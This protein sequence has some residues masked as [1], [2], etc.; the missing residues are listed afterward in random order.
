ML[1]FRI[2]ILLHVLS[3]LFLGGC[4]LSAKTNVDLLDDRFL[5]SSTSEN[6]VGVIQMDWITLQPMKT[7]DQVAMGF[8]LIGA[9]VSIAMQSSEDADNYEVETESL[10][11]YERDLRQ[12]KQ[13]LSEQSK[14]RF[15]DSDNL[16]KVD[17]VEFSRDV[18]SKRGW[19]WDEP[20]DEQIQAYFNETHHD[21]AIFVSSLGGIYE[22]DDTLFV[23]TTWGILDKAG[24]EVVSVFTRNVGGE[25]DKETIQ[26]ASLVEELSK[27][28]SKNLEEFLLVINGEMPVNSSS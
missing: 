19:G 3:L 17:P 16:E 20:S 28:F 14:Y 5:K 11:L 8:G 27:L 22:N 26:S 6:T 13:R 7:R 24:E 18:R 9:L 12:L 25:V 15:I 23:N 1:T 4:S 2:V 21:Y 10:S